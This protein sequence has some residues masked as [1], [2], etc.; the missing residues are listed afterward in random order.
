MKLRQKK[1]AISDSHERKM[2]IDKEISIKRQR[3]RIRLDFPQHETL[4]KAV[5]HGKKKIRRRRKNIKRENLF[6]E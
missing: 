3:N 1:K 5:K 6:I 2:K 4:Y